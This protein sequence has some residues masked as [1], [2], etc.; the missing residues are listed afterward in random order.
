M[1]TGTLHGKAQLI[2]P[3]MAK[4]LKYV[5]IKIHIF[6]ANAKWGKFAISENIH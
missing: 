2:I 1:F 5:R 6:Y 3:I 4:V